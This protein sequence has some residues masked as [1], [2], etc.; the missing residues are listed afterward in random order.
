M[1]YDP[2]DASTSFFVLPLIYSKD[3]NDLS[4]TVSIDWKFLDKVSGYER[5]RRE[6]QIHDVPDEKKFSSNRS[7]FEDAV[8]KPNY[9]PA[10]DQHH[11]YVAAICD[12]LNPL[13]PFSNKAHGIFLNYYKTKYGVTISDLNQPL[14]DHASA[15][16]NLLTP[17][18]VNRKG[19]TVP[20]SS[21]KTRES[22]REN[23]GEKQILIPELCVVHPLPAS[24][25]NKVKCLPSISTRLNQ[26][27]LAEELREK[28]AKGIG[29]G[30]LNPPSDI[31]W[32]PL[33]FGWTLMVKLGN[34]QIHQKR[35]TLLLLSL[36]FSLSLS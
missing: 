16:L 20:M 11:F 3:C 23:L 4:K 28:V 35:N 8:V 17:R 9:R 27:L 15:R 5:G 1:K 10:D 34:T 29:I 12:H 19:M 26:L 21:Q 13:S 36:S 14:L 33:D 30:I 7:L 6:N 2:D 32:P 25:W 24:F 22:M 31:K 18:Y